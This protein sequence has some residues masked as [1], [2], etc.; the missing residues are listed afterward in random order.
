MTLTPPTLYLNHHFIASKELCFKDRQSVYAPMVKPVETPDFR[1]TDLMVVFTNTH[2]TPEEVCT[3]VV[4]ELIMVVS[5]QSYPE[6]KDSGLR[7]GL[8]VQLYAHFG[9]PS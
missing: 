4:R 9:F 5:H 6:D 1:A 7:E 3:K 8:A 2:G